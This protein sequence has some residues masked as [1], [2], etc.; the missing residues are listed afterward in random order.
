MKPIDLILSVLK[1]A[2]QSGS[3]KWSARCPVHGDEHASL[4]FG[5]FP[6]GGVWLRCHAGCA[7]NDV[8]KAVG[9]TSSQI[10][11]HRSNGTDQGAKPKEK[12][13]KRFESLELAVADTARRL[14]ASAGERWVYPTDEGEE[15]AWMVRFDFPG[16]GTTKAKKT[17]R[18]YH[19]DGLGWVERDPTALWPLYRRPGITSA[20]TVLLF[21]GER[22][23]NLAARL[24]YVATTSAHGS[25][26]VGKSD[27]RPLVNKDLVAFADND[28][29][30]RKYVD[31]VVV[32]LAKL[33]SSGRFK[34]VQL[35]GLPL[36]GDIMD[37]YA[38]RSSAGKSDGDI[39]A[40]IDA[41]IDAT[42][43][44]S[45]GS[46]G[47][48]N[49]TSGEREEEEWPE[50]LPLPIA[51]PPVAPFDPDLLPKAFRTWIVD[52]SERMQCPI[53][54]VAVA[55][56]VGLSGI[57]GRRVGI[58]PKRYDTWLVVPNLWGGV[59]GRPAVMKSPALQDA[60]KP[61]HELEAK[62]KQEHV[63]A[64]KDYE[65]DQMVGEARE[66]EAKRQI[67]DALK[68]EGGGEEEARRIARESRQSEAVPI[69]TR[70]VVNDTTVE[71]LGEILNQN[72]AGVILFRDELIGFL[73]SLD[74][75]GH[76]SDRAFYLEAWNGTSPCTCDRIGRGTIDIESTCVAI[77]GGI[78]PGPLHHYLS[79]LAKGGAGDDGFLQRFQLLVWPE[80][81]KEWENVDRPHDVAARRLAF[82]VF[83]GLAKIDET[84]LLAEID[85]HDPLGI[86]FVRF[87]DEAQVVFNEWRADL[88]RH[89]RSDVEHTAMEAHL[90]KFRSLIPSLALLIHLADDGKNPVTVGPLRKAIAWGK[91]LET[92]AR[93]IYSQATHPDLASAL[94]LAK[95]IVAGLVPDGFGTRDVHRKGWSGLTSADAVKGAIQVLLDFEWLSEGQRQTPGRTATF[96]RINPRL[97]GSD[98]AES[99]RKPPPSTDKADKRGNGGASGGSVGGQS[100]KCPDSEGEVLP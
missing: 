83:E 36:K 95:K 27:W 43:W 70:Y 48:G 97:H 1:D 10:R 11:P 91:Y 32:R 9:L 31:D 53:D 92:H 44:S 93:R 49:V 23:A 60:L 14:R 55:A 85:P 61:I 24:D 65:V 51:L 68:E 98:A 21:E 17:F 52:I 12:P 84:L 81:G 63:E 64:T 82:S 99:L 79:A 33:G 16:D 56:M 59:I 57:V 67:R 18:P 5:V 77:L 25:Q 40:E 87:D 50:P 26:A 15:F 3:A 45:V 4:G 29:A 20:A 96:Y 38:A 6:D 86:C 62:A 42:P 22:K 75:E 71:K 76:D 80:I 37:F 100:G 66:K 72:P 39:R 73:K 47:G 30:G 8:L 78:Q 2:K 74:R 94:E 35:P 54:Y 41:L 58:R 28:E 7:E 89:I 19:H 34:S 88:E 13:V 46:V 90:G 69:R